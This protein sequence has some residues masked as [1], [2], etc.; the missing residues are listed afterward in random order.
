MQ[1]NVL[2]FQCFSF[3]D[4]NSKLS[5]NKTQLA[6]K[7]LVLD[8]RPLKIE[9]GEVLRRTNLFCSGLKIE[10]LF[11]EISDRTKTTLASEIFSKIR[12]L[13]LDV[14]RISQLSAVEFKNLMNLMKNSDQ[15]CS[16]KLSIHLLNRSQ[17]QVLADL[18]KQKQNKFTT[19]K[20]YF[21]NT[22]KGING[23]LVLSWKPIFNL[24][25][26]E[27]LYFSLEV[28]QMPINKKLLGKIFKYIK[29]KNINIEANAQNF[30]W[31][32]LISVENEEDF[33]GERPELSLSLL[34]NH[35][36]KR[37]QKNKVMPFFAYL[38]KNKTMMH[39][40]LTAFPFNIEVWS[41]HFSKLIFQKKV[42]KKLTLSEWHTKTLLTKH[43]SD[44]STSLVKGVHSLL[45]R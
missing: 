24:N 21:L 18:I 3:E 27:R 8:I 44:N 5:T 19:Q 2:S 4:L 16:F 7:L 31:K 32:V 30:L 9:E 28:F 15:I 20:F 33:K 29:A 23:N 1:P 13:T 12:F 36:V 43:Y 41:F 39:L 45:L 14:S 22:K 25:C 42:E 10:H 6:S 35:R 26:I 17:I 11:F 34:C 37:R 38:L 40:N